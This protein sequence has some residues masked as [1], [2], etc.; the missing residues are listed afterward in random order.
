MMKNKRLLVDYW[1]L[2]QEGTQNTVNNYLGHA[3][4]E[5]IPFCCTLCLVVLE[6]LEQL[7]CSGGLNTRQYW[8]LLVLVLC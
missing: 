1:Q 3:P 4:E 7:R 8:V 2:L 6:L 5:P